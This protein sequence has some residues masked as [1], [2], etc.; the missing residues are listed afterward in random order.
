MVIFIQRMKKFIYCVLIALIALSCDKADD[1]LE[2]TP[3]VIPKTLY[4]QASVSDLNSRAVSEY[5]PEG[6]DDAETVDSRTYAVVD[7]DNASEYFQYWSPSNAISVFCTTKNLQ[8]QMNS[9]KD[10]TLDIGKF[11]L[12]GNASQGTTLTTKKALECMAIIKKHS[13]DF[14]GSLEDPD[15]IKLC[16]CSRNSYYKYKKEAKSN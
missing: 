1:P 6:W 10:G 5:Q 7:P 9:Y 15:V 11:E 3:V 8:Y 16:G 14:G 2:N 12:V 4:A 13:K